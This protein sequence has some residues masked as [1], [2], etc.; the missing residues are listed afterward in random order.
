MIESEKRLRELN[1]K[2]NSKDKKVVSDAIISLRG[3]DPFKGAIGLLADLYN[4]SNNLIIKDLIQNFLND[5]KDPASRKEVVKEVL[6]AYKSETISM[7]VA[8]CWQSGLD[9]SE[10]VI[11]FANVFIKGDYLTALECF[12]VIEESVPNITPAG[13]I[14]IISFLQQ[15]KETTSSEKS[16]LLQAL[17]TV[18]G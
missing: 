2:L 5:I 6:K 12:T 16:T 9:Y 7:L 13:K 18:L 8:S 17:I 14:E 1:A 11:D 10:Y 15:S 4:S 3:E